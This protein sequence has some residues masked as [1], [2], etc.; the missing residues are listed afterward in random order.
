MIETYTAVGLALMAA[1]ISGL[2]AWWRGH[3][4]GTSEGYCDGHLAGHVEGYREGQQAG[5]AGRYMPSPAKA[6]GEDLGGGPR[7]RA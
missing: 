6:P 3:L 5:L 4:V 1:V 2:L 7:E